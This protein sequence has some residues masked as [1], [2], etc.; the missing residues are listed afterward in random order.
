VRSL[1]L[2]ALLAALSACAPL[3]L[4]GDAAVGAAQVVVGAAD[5]A[6]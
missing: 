2:I 5:L 6:L 4:A 3:E 1:T